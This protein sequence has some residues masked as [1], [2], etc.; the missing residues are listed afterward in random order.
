MFLRVS[1]VTC[2]AVGWKSRAHHS[3]DGLLGSIPGTGAGTGDEANRGGPTARE[4]TERH[5]PE[6]FRSMPQ[7]PQNCT[8]DAPDT[9]KGWRTAGRNIREASPA[10]R[11]LRRLITG[12][13][14]A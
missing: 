4:T 8:G 2:F 1:P 7:E 6:V 14:Q 11:T 5:R 12:E 3:E 13:D 9:L 10:Q